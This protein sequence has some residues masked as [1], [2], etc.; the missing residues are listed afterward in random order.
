[1]FKTTFTT[2]GLPYFKASVKK[3]VPTAEPAN[4]RKLETP[5]ARADC[6]NFVQLRDQN[7]QEHHQDKNVFPKNDYF[8]VEQ[9]V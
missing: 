1:M 6:G 3:I 9:F 5:C 4:P 8:S 2:V 7:W